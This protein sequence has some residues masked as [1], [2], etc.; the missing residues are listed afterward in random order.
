MI[1]SPRAH[2]NVEDLIDAALGRVVCLDG[3]NFSGRSALIEDCVKA[4]SYREHFAIHL[5]PETPLSG[6][7]STVMEE[8]MLHLGQRDSSSPHWRLA[9]EWGFRDLESRSLRHLSGGQ[10]ALLV[11]LCKLALQPRLLGLD[12]ALEQLDPDN[13]LR[14]LDALERPGI[15]HDNAVTLIA[16]NGT[17]PVALPALPLASPDPLSHRPVM[18]ARHFRAFGIPEPVDIRIENSSYAYRSGLPVFRNL[19]LELQ[20]GRVHRLAGPNGAGK[21]TLALILMGH[22]SLNSGRILAAGNP[23]IPYKR[24]GSLASYHFQRPDDQLFASSVAAEIGTLPA[25]SRETALAFSGLDEFRESHPFD[26]PFVLRKRLALGVALPLPTP[27]VIVDEPTLG[28]DAKNRA[29]I[30]C[31]LRQLADAGH[32]VLLITH[33]G[34]FA[35][36]VVDNT[37]HLNSHQTASSDDSE[38]KHR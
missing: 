38:K 1:E 6:L 19:N 22:L 23:I 27:W 24:P 32:G 9:T 35:E 2:E 18:Q 15:L 8:L 37:I 12:G 36:T 17:L 26:L 3:G 21:T 5:P 13:I 11:I 34:P 29:E 33:D 30:A 25:Q 16:H 7:T 4:A 10:V 20:A 14:V 28:Q 31:V